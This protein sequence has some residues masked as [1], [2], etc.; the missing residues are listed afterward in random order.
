MMYFTAACNHACKC[1]CRLFY[2]Y[3]WVR[4]SL[5]WGHGLQN[6][7][8]HTSVDTDKTPTL[9]NFRN[10]FIP[11]IPL[12]SHVSTWFADISRMRTGSPG[13]T[14]RIIPIQHKLG[15]IKVE[16]IIRRQASKLTFI[17]QTRGNQ[18]AAISLTDLISKCY[19]HTQVIDGSMNLSHPW[20]LPLH[21]RCRKSYLDDVKKI[22]FFR[23]PKIV[24]L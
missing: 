9:S 11:G 19:I 5:I 16:L 12:C 7:F 24:L 2:N 22:R 6:S 15:K 13:V 21:K 4:L 23:E 8:R 18:P 20:K 3:Y 17:F 10:M 14:E 1:V